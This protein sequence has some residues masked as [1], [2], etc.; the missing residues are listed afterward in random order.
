MRGVLTTMSK[1][2][3]K[4]TF[5]KPLFRRGWG[6]LY[7]TKTPWWLKKIYP[8]RLWNVDTKEKIIYL[9]FDD[10]PH[11]VAT[12]F[13]LDELKKYKAKAT[14]FCI[15]KNVVNYPELYSRILQEG[16]TTGNHTYHH[17]NGWKT[18]TISYLA[19]VA[20][21]TAKIETNLFRPPYGR[22]KRSQA[23]GIE[24]ALNNKSSKIVMWDVLS[25]DF[26]E[27]VSKEKC[28]KN[29][30]ENTTCGS[31]I[32]FHDSEKAFPRLKFVLP[33]TLEFFVKSGYVFEKIEM[34]QK[35]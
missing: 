19:D 3:K 1:E 25:G 14:F 11:P 26:D 28:L 18:A 15:G 4:E 6:R 23:K 35:N 22:I 30:I 10:G 24:N 31:I 8:N 5:Q 27:S 9:T 21:A 7:F 12:T 29:V 32:V 20:E 17:L 2:E 16:H 34:Q 13:I 33:A